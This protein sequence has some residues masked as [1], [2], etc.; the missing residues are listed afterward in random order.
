MRR[1]FGCQRRSSSGT[2]NKHSKN[3]CKNDPVIELECTKRTQTRNMKF[4]LPNSDSLPIKEGRAVE[5]SSLDSTSWSEY[6]VEVVGPFA[7][8]WWTRTFSM[9]KNVPCSKKFP[10]NNILFRMLLKQ[11]DGLILQ[12][13]S[14]KAFVLRFFLLSWYIIRSFHPSYIL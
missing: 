8:R 1:L 14:V 4:I 7:F 10:V 9:R 3:Q 6:H 2:D 11:S 13:S 5:R 12:T